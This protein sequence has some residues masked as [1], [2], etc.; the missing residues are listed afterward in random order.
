MLGSGMST[1]TPGHSGG[2]AREAPGGQS[3]SLGVQGSAGS[4]GSLLAP[5]AAKQ[6]ALP[7]WRAHQFPYCLICVDLAPFSCVCTIEDPVF[8]KT[9]LL[10]PRDAFSPACDA[11]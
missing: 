2:S 3:M 6:V 10:P 1:G 9:T 5:H 8:G 4:R 7:F 11:F